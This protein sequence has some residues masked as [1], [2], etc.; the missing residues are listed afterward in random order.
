M[1]CGKGTNELKVLDALHF[2]AKAWNDVKQSTVT[3][4]FHKGGI[5]AGV[6][7]VMDLAEEEELQKVDWHTLEPDCT[8]SDFISVDD[9]VLTMEE[10]S[11][12]EVIDDHLQEDNISDCDCSDGD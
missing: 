3:N 5:H 6:V 10:Q 1:D 11:L 4:C 8:L 7:E 9:E 2:I 12:E